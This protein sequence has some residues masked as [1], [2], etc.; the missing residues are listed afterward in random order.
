ML[1]Q[2]ENSLEAWQVVQ[3]R[4]LVYLGLEQTP[5]T[6]IITSSTG[7]RMSAQNLRRWWQSN[8]ETLGV[9]CTLHELRHTFLTMLANSGASAQSLKS[10]AGWSSIE[11]AKVYIHDDDTANR[12]A[13]NALEARF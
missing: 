7:T 13:V 5:K 9:Y 6:P 4:K 10:I 8:R 1:L 12:S 11:M 2:L 3:S